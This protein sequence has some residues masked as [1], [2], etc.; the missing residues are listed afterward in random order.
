MFDDLIRTLRNLDGQKINLPVECDEDGYLDRECPNTACEFGFKIHAEDWRAIVRDEEVFC[1][2]CG[3]AAPAQSWFTKAHVEAARKAAMSHLKGQINQAMRRDAERW[4]RRQS[5]NAFI[6]I[7]MQVKGHT[8]PML[9]PLAAAEPMRLKIACTK[10]HCRYSV[11]GSAYFCPSCG[12][13]AADQVFSQSLDK[14][15]ASLD[16][17]PLLRATITD[18]DTAENTIRQLT[19][20][21]LQRAVTAFQRF[22]EALFAEHPSS[23]K[24]RR[25]AFQN[26]DEGSRLWAEAFQHSY[27]QHLTTLELATLKRYFQQR[28]LMAHRDGLVDAEYV[29]KSGDGTYRAGQRLVIQ[30]DEVRECVGLIE[31]LGNAMR[32]DRQGLALT[33]LDPD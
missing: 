31:K 16:L 15:R 9:L 4:N 26:L 21:G 3:H 11:I 19:E 10:C 13:N 6:S 12:H 30:A 8:K 1:P 22:A 28:H 2:S 7:T 20:D 24:A 27:D 25:N 32:L 33:D 18:R 5:P 29:T 17:A 14:I 23:L